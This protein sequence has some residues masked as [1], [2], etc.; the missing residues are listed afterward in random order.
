MQ[1]VQNPSCKRLLSRGAAF[2]TASAVTMTKV[3][4]LNGVGVRSQEEESLWC[5]QQTANLRPLAI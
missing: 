3:G 2:C 4:L 1:V 5:L